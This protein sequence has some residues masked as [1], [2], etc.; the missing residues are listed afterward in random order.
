MALTLL[1]GHSPFRQWQVYR[2]HH[3]IVAA[4]AADRVAGDLA[5]AIAA[6]LRE[7]LPETQSVPVDAS[8]NHELISLLRS[9]QLKL[10][11]LDLRAARAA[12][13]GTGE[14][15]GYGITPVR[16]VFMLKDY[17]LVGLEDLPDAVAA[18]IAGALQAPGLIVPVGES[19]ARN[20]EAPI[21]LHAGAA[22]ALKDLPLGR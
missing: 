3:L 19:Q 12:L 2:E 9:H 7:R 21:P 1:S 13:D 22:N 6:R 8:D 17:V 4:A 11:I 16:M 18:R 20:L 14:F 10:V 5:E 15:A